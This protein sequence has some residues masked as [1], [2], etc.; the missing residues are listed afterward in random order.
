MNNVFA[1]SSKLFIEIQTPAFR[2]KFSFKLLLLLIF[3]SLFYDFKD[4]DEC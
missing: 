3:S 2:T 1:A 4:K